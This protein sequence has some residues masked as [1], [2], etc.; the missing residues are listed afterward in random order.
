MRRSIIGISL[1]LSLALAASLVVGWAATSKPNPA[2]KVQ[3]KPSAQTHPIPEHLSY[4]VLFQHKVMLDQK[5]KEVEAQKGNGS[6]YRSGLKAVASLSDKEAQLLEQV[7]HETYEK[8]KAQ[9]AKA[10]QIIEALRKQSPDGNFQLGKGNPEVPP[11]LKAMQIE[12]DN[13]IK[14]GMIKLADGFGSS[15]FLNLDQ[16][17]KKNITPNFTNLTPNS[18]PRNFDPRTDPRIQ[19]MIEDARR[20]K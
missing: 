9:D 18:P 4:W 1:A 14:A 7:S 19:K 13:M 15:R 2:P 20:S 16:F 6:P 11:V 5:A 8:V 10:K 12:R 3:D 17:V